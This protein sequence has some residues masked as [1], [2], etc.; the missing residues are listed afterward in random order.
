MAKKLD[1]HEAG[2]KAREDELKLKENNLKAPE[3]NGRPRLRKG[4]A[5]FFY[6]TEEQ[7]K[8][9]VVHKWDPLRLKQGLNY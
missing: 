8:K 5:V 9:S 1:F 2:K 3:L 7:L 4:K 6:K